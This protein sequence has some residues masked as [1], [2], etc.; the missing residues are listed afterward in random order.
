MLE[1]PGAGTREGQASTR[2]DDVQVLV[3]GVRGA[4][5]A[6]DVADLRCPVNPS[7]LF[8]RLRGPVIV[9]GNLIEVACRDCRRGRR[10]RVLHR[11]DVLGNLVETVEVSLE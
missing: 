1:E 2:R 6:G 10:V 4:G 7:R 3:G 8:A 5:G 9:E 11:F